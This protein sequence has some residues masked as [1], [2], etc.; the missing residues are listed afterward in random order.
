MS[1]QG[2]PGGHIGPGVLVAEGMGVTD[3]VG[4]ENGEIVGVSMGEVHGGETGAE[5]DSPP[6]T[7]GKYNFATAICQGVAI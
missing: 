7:S 3:G 5:S 2:Q 4:V 6:T 1:P